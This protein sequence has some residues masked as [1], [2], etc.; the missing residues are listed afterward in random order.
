MALN[1]FI[2]TTLDTATRLGR[3]LLE[4][5]TGW[6][7]RYVPSLVIVATAGALALSGQWRALWPA[8]G[9]SNQ[10]VAALALLVV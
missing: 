9:A 1:F 6:R 5:L 7:N 10:L 3:Y 8:F 4:E 2:L